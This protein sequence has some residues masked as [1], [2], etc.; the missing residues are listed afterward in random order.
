MKN[1]F[2]CMLRIFPVAFLIL[3]LVISFVPSPALAAVSSLDWFDYIDSMYIDK[4]TALYGHIAFDRFSCTWL[5]STGSGSSSFA[6][7][8]GNTAQFQTNQQIT[9]R[10][11]SNRYLDLKEIPMGSVIYAS[12]ELTTDKIYST[13]EMSYYISL[14]YFDENGVQVF[15]QTSPRT[16]FTFNDPSAPAGTAY[17]NCGF[18]LAGV[19]VSNSSELYMPRYCQIEVYLSPGINV[20]FEAAI[21]GVSMNLPFND[22]LRSKLTDD[23]VDL[24][25]EILYDRYL[26]VVNGEQLNTFDVSTLYYSMAS[27]L[28]VPMKGPIYDDVLGSLGDGDFSPIVSD[29]VS[30]LGSYAS[31]F[32]A[33]GALFSLF[34]QLPLLPAL[35]YVSLALGI[36]MSVLGLFLV[37]KNQKSDAKQGGSKGKKGGG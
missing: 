16:Y 20:Y 2:S 26:A 28:S 31:A 34:S 25:A 32:I 9:I 13:R 27:F 8:V 4:V 37:S 10:P 21:T 17:I 1:I 29:A 36:V 33:V 18:T 23:R 7:F 12:F 5:H 30:Q 3:A 15:S 11:L 19:P 6:S 14:K 35:L 24:L 22:D